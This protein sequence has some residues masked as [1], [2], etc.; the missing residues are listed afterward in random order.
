MCEESYMPDDMKAA[1][2]NLIEKRVG[3]I[4]AS[5]QHSIFCKNCIFFTIVITLFLIVLTLMLF[6]TV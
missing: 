4:G 6:Q 3:V 1:L 2:K 5:R